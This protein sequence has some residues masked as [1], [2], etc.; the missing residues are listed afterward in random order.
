VGYGFLIILLSLQ[1]SANLLTK[2]GFETPVVSNAT[3]FLLFNQGDSIGGW[4]AIK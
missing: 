3:H 4:N 1:G 2:G